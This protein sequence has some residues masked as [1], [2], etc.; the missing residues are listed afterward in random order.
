MSEE[1]AESVTSAIAGL[2][3]EYLEILKIEHPNSS[4]SI[5]TKSFE[6]AESDLELIKKEREDL[7]NS[8]ITV[9]KLLGS[10]SKVLKLF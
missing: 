6:N 10:I 8:F 7:A 4:Y 9:T 3:N 1:Q 2:E 5:I